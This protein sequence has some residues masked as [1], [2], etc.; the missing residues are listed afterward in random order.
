MGKGGVGECMI[1][2]YNL[3]TILMTSGNWDFGIGR[4]QSIAETLTTQKY[5]LSF[6]PSTHLK[7]G[8]TFYSRYLSAQRKAQ[9]DTW[10]PW[11]T[12]LA[13][14]SER[15][16]IKNKT[17]HN[18]QKILC[19]E[20]GMYCITFIFIWKDKNKMKRGPGFLHHT[21]D[22]LAFDRVREKGAITLVVQPRI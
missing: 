14:N 15:S 5:D 21:A 13:H 9:N 3:Q 22:L 2:I 11:L 18:K 6:V 10:A 1:R 20:N 16:Y 12:T 19:E 17:K 4:D 7:W 8:I